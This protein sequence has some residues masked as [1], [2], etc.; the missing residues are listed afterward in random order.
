M[1]F[2]LT[3][4]GTRQMFRKRGKGEIKGRERKEGKRKED[5]WGMEGGQGLSEAFAQ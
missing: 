1:W 3:P 4:E 5:A 2:Y